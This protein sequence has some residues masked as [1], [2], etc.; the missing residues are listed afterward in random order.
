MY[1]YSLTF[2]LLFHVWISSFVNEN[3]SSG[4]S[5]NV[6]LARS[7]E[8]TWESLILFI[9]RHCIWKFSPQYILQTEIIRF[10]NVFLLSSLVWKYFFWRECEV[11][12]EQNGLNAALE[13]HYR[14]STWRN[15]EHEVG[16]K[17]LRW[18]VMWHFV[19]A[20]VKHAFAFLL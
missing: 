2:S 3:N 8:T 11:C 6:L 10:R 14:V 15:L 12:E 16:R 17:A 18:A 1:R 7:C 19:I 4:E 20:S 9:T 5:R 13:R